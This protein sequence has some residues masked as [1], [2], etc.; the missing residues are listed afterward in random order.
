[1]FDDGNIALDHIF[2]YA[3][4]DGVMLDSKVPGISTHLMDGFI[5]QVARAWLD[6]TDRPVRAANVLRCRK[7]AILDVYKRQYLVKVLMPR[8]S[9]VERP[10]F[11]FWRVP[12]SFFA[13]GI[14]SIQS[15]AG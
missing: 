5:Q 14:T 1:M 13:T 3:Y 2:A 10:F 15:I 7:G 12:F 4:R 8:S 9:W 6:L 11:F